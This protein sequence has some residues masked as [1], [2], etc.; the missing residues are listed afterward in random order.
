[1]VLETP[2]LFLRELALTDASFI[3]ELL[4]TEGWLRY[5]GDRGVHS[6]ADAENY[7]TSGPFESYRTNGFGLWLVVRKEDSMRLGMCG[8]LKRPILN[9][10]DVGFAYLPEFTRQ[11]YAGESLRG[12]LHLARTRFSLQ[13]VC[14]ITTPDNNASQKVLASAGFEFSGTTLSE[15]NEELFLYMKDLND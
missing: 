14:A 6:E 4:N 9:H 11:G 10:P 15:K 2:R 8:I 5:I 12:I 7:L 13:K 1:M 3:V